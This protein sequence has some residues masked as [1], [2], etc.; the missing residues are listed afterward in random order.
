MILTIGC[1][2]GGIGGSEEILLSAC[3]L[4][5]GPDRDCLANAISQV[6]N[7]P[8]LFQSEQDI[9]HRFAVHGSPDVNAE[10]L[11]RKAVWSWYEAGP[12]SLEEIM[13]RP[14]DRSPSPGEAIF[15][16]AAWLGTNWPLARVVPLSRAQQYMLLLKA[17]GFPMAKAGESGSWYAETILSGLNMGT[18]KRLNVS[19]Q[20]LR[21]NARAGLE[22]IWDANK[23]LL[24]HMAGRPLHRRPEVKRA[25]AIISNWLG[26]KRYIAE[27]EY[28]P[29]ISEA[30]IDLTGPEPRGA[31]VR[32]LARAY[33]P[34]V[35]SDVEFF[36]GGGSVLALRG[37]VL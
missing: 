4:G 24:G 1:G 31:S 8:E 17:L 10:E 16:A 18:A 33:A 9:Y 28:G 36:G 6:R 26:E 25:I 32:K 14:V 34:E 22:L 5:N 37:R 7:K 35:W 12:A 3:G 30:C 21:M 29:L 23:Q 20:R 19:V 27:L 15:S 11:L 13:G 2:D